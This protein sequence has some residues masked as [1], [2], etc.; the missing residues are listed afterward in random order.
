MPERSTSSE[1]RK[2]PRLK[3]SCVLRFRQVEADT[4]PEEGVDALTVNISG[5]GICFSSPSAVEVGT[6]LAIELTLPDFNSAVVSFGRAVWCEPSGG[7][8]QVGLEFWW[9]GWGDDGAQRAITEYIK[10]TLE[11]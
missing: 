2:F 3:D 8:F 5:G 7:K 9:I 10:N 1:N 11:P 4:L 6:L